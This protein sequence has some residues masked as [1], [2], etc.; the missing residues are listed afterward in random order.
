MEPVPPQPAPPRIGPWLSR[1]M[2]LFGEAWSV[3]VVHGLLAML[4]PGLLMGGAL[5]P[6]V[7]ALVTGK[8]TTPQQ[9]FDLLAG[10]SGVGTL[11]AVLCILVLSTAML[12]TALAQLRGER[13]G[14]AAAFAPRGLA[15]AVGMLLLFYVLQ[16]L[17]LVLCIVPH[18][19]I[20]GALLYAPLLVIDR[21]M[22]IAEACGASIRLTRPY[23]WTY[24]LWWLLV[25][26]IVAA[27]G[28]LCVGYVATIPI[29]ALMLAVSYHETVEGEG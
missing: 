8:A 20:G 25:E 23:L 21:R 24:A 4:L 3:W 18:F 6:P 22:G 1:A 17:G 19:L 12:R 9:F 13:L 28:V 16:A 15:A 7:A 29:G 2:N 5:V 26:F 10:W 27:G 14:I 11:A